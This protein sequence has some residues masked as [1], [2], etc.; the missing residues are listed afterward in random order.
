MDSNNIDDNGES[1]NGDDDISDDVDH[2]IE[3]T[4]NDDCSDGE[5]G[6]NDDCSE[7]NESCNA[8][9]DS[10]IL[11]FHFTQPHELADVVESL[12]DSIINTQVYFI[13]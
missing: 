6:T 7:D 11:D 4:C 13:P 2:D 1:S 12:F 9:D 8:C 10:G 5:P 3:D